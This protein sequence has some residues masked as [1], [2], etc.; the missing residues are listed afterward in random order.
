MAGFNDCVAAAV[1]SLQGVI[2]MSS[3]C[4]YIAFNLSSLF[5]NVSKKEVIMLSIV[6]RATTNNH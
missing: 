5:R 2:G 1:V 6:V 3:Q 4:V